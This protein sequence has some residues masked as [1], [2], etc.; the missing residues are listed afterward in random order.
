[1]AGKPQ[2]RTARWQA[3]ASAAADALATLVEIQGEYQDWLANLPENFEGSALGEKLNAVCD[4][5]LEEARDAALE[6][7]GADLPLGFGRD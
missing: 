1:M 3:A 4:L 7:E 6:A 5:E 2:S